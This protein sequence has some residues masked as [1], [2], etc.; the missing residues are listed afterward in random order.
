MNLYVVGVAQTQGNKSAF[1]YRK[2]EIGVDGKRKLGVKVMEG[3]T[4]EAADRVKSWK[5]AIRRA[6]EIQ[7]MAEGNPPPLDGPVRLIC[8]F[9]LPR[10]A[11]A[12]KRVTMPIKKPDLDKLVRAV[13]DALKGTIYVDDSQIV[14]KQARKLFAVGCVPHAEIWIETINQEALR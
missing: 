2:K 11:S 3:R 1:P 9:Y 4:P 8:E 7:I 10:P 12:P 13:G 6:A 5:A 14:E